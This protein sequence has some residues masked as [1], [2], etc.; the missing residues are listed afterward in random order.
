MEELQSVLK[1][2]HVVVGVAKSELKATPTTI[3]PL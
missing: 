1:P 2:F 3:L